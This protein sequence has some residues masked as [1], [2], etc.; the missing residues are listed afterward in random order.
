MR[1][2]DYQPAYCCHLGSG[3]IAAI[4]AVGARDITQEIVIANNNKLEPNWHLI[5]INSSYP[6]LDLVSTFAL[7]MLDFPNPAL[8]TAPHIHIALSVSF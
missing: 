1:I 8:A 7:A 5:A 2:T 4:L 3:L 6:M